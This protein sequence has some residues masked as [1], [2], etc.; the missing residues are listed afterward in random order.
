M[1]QQ[2]ISKCLLCSGH[3]WLKDLHHCLVLIDDQEVEG[4]ICESCLDIYHYRIVVK[5]VG[6]PKDLV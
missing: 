5:F 2:V 1:D 6:G 3:F 4:Y